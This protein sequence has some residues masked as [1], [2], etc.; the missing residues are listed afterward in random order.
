M[1]LKIQGNSKNSEIRA[2]EPEFHDKLKSCVERLIGVKD[3]NYTCITAI[4]KMDDILEEINVTK[5][6][7]LHHLYGKL[8]SNFSV[9]PESKRTEQNIDVLNKIDDIV[10]SYDTLSS[11]Y[12]DLVKM[13]GGRQ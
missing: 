8:P 10:N 6:E 5:Q 12:E 3:S 2:D 7:L 11:K 1:K 13:L 4:D 9:I